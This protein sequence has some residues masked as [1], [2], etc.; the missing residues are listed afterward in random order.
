MISEELVLITSRFDAALERITKEVEQ[1]SQ[2]MRRSFEGAGSKKSGLLDGLT[3]GLTGGLSGAGNNVLGALGLGGGI[4]GIG[5]AIKDSLGRADDIADLTLKLNESA[6]ALQRVDF[7][8]KLAAGQGVDQVA[9]AMVKLERALGDPENEKAAQALRNL[10]VTAQQLA[11]VPIDER[12]VMLADAFQK[13]RASGTGLSD[14]Q[15]L[16][17]RN[18]AELIPLLEQGG[19]ALREMF[20][21]APVLAEATV[22][23]MA[24]I[25]DEFDALILKGKGLVMQ[26]VSGLSTVRD[27]TEAAMAAQAG[28][29]PSKVGI[30]L[31]DMIN[32]GFS[33]AR[34]LFNFTGSEGGINKARQEQLDRE[35]QA[36]AEAAER[37]R[38]RMRTGTAQQ[39]A[40]E[41]A[42]ADA[43]QEAKIAAADKAEEEILKRREEAERERE[44]KEKEALAQR[45]EYDDARFDTMT[46][47]QQLA[48]LLKRMSGAM[49]VTTT[50]EAEILKKADELASSGATQEAMI[51]LQTLQEIR[52]LTARM[53]GLGGMG[54]ME[55]TQPMHQGSFADLM[56]QI[57]ERDQRALTNIATNT[58]NA[59]T[60][61]DRI[62]EN[63]ETPPDEDRF[64]DL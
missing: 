30:S 26:A 8:G 54:A 11:A 2:R 27:A 62:L 35:I 17:G 44:R 55:R 59:K 13:A 9:N 3:S 28:G 37:N 6:E 42:A 18:S 36:Q 45:K 31:M 20:A 5:L 15:A 40:A 22:Q 52:T 24:K 32:P 41:K 64:D 63:M 61:L 47:E 60:V 14:I 12:I 53:G 34:L 23:E 29:D 1:K 4:A 56:D 38:T 25:N 57:F 7:A 43:A 51:M 39:A 46:P 48:T 19:D 10:G 50:D 21:D 58:G 16:L 49:G 33:A